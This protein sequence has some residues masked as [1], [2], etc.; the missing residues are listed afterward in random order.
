MSQS[1]FLTIYFRNK[2]DKNS[3]EKDMKQ[4]RRIFRILWNLEGTGFDEHGN[5][6][7]LIDLYRNMEYDSD[8]D[9]LEKENGELSILNMEPPDI[10]ENISF[11]FH[12]YGGNLQLTKDIELRDIYKLFAE[13]LSSCFGYVVKL[14][15]SYDEVK[16]MWFFDEDGKFYQLKEE[17]ENRADYLRAIKDMNTAERSIKIEKDILEKAKKILN[18]KGNGFQG[19]K[20]NE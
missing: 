4:A 10:A 20:K 17:K 6:N 13:I 7:G 19:G 15:D 3:F 9:D 8:A 12:N 16:Y 11:N 18:I 1:M 14:S 5:I 2:F